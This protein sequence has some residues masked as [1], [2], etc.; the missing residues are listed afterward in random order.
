MSCRFDIGDA[1]QSS[2]QVGRL[3]TIAGESLLKKTRVSA[4]VGLATARWGAV[5]A[6]CP[7][8]IA[9]GCATEVV[10]QTVVVEREIVV[11]REVE[12]KVPAEVVKEVPFVQT[13]VVEKQVVVDRE[14]EIEVPVEV[15]KKVLVVQTVVVEK[16]VQV[17]VI[18][19]VVVEKELVVEKRSSKRSWLK[20]RRLRTWK[21]P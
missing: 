1:P 14:V 5:F 2:C 10:V 8:L 11:E 13:V 20:S 15:V 19:T 6:V 12:I 21:T 16:E 9:T 18:Q 4:R 17:P 3:D 7:L